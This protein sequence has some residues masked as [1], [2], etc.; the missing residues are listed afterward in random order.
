MGIVKVKPKDFLNETYDH[1]VYTQLVCNNYAQRKDG[2]A[3]QKQDFYDHPEWFESKFAPFT[4]ASDLMINGIYWDNNAPVFFTKEEMRKE[5]FKIKV[6]AD[7]TCDIAPVSSIPSTLR[8]STIAD[9][10]FG[11]DPQQ[12]AETEALQTDS[13]DM[14]TIDN[15]PNELPRDASQSFGNQFVEYILPEL[16]KAKSDILERATVAENGQLGKYF[17]YLENYVKGE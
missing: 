13:I 16:L 9:P 12:E 6:I 3:F 2:S 11:Y 4:K 14:M 10:I 1:G 17:Q 7:V 15:L 8:A 5:D